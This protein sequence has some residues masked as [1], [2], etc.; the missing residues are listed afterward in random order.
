MSWFSN[1]FNSKA[2]TVRPTNSIKD[3]VP[4]P[5]RS[6][7]F[8]TKESPEKY[9]NPN[10]FGIT[11]NI[12]N[13]TTESVNN[14]GVAFSEPSL[15]WERLPI[16]VNQE[17]EGDKLYYPTYI[18][19][20]PRQRYQ[21]LQWLKD[22][23]KETNLSYVFLYYYGL[24]RHLILGDYENAFNEILRLIKYH[25]KGTFRSYSQSSL[26]ISS[27]YHKRFDL[28]KGTDILEGSSNEIFLVKRMMN[29]DI[30]AANLID[31]A[32]RIGF[33]N[34]RYIKMHPV[35]FEEI[36]NRK[37]QENNGILNHI[38]LDELKKKEES[39][40]GN[41]SIPDSVRC[42]KVPQLITNTLFK[43]MTKKLLEATHEEIKIKKKNK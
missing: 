31:I 37:I 5:T 1:L 10:S 38:N 29:Q 3:T 4:E 16:K 11:L 35:I 26:I 40:F 21:Y 28:F 12:A 43:K 41:T 18:G 13:G 6:L 39:F 27:L 22:I 30:D 19:L 25:D 36:L 7:I 33:T 9:R 34:K 2:L 32:S 23:T 24:E 20:S 17:I 42:I 8:S 15:V 14:K